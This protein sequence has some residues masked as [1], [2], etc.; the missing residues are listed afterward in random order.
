LERQY[1]HQSHI[2]LCTPG[3]SALSLWSN[4][5]SCDEW[6]GTM[7]FKKSSWKDQSFKYHC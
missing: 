5:C 3:S 1:S 7:Q 2:Y 6:K 4:E